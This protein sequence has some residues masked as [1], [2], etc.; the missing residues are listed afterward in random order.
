MQS[1]GD[2]PEEKPEGPYPFPGAQYLGTV[3]RDPAQA[4]GEPPKD[5][6]PPTQFEIPAAPPSGT[7]LEIDSM[8][9]TTEEASNRTIASLTA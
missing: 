4:E 1:E 7:R 3:P 2:D 9:E 6:L 8:P 5:K